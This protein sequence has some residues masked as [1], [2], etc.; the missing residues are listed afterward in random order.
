MRLAYHAGNV[1][2]GGRRGGTALDMGTGTGIIALHLQSRGWRCIAADNNKRA[3]QCAT[4][5]AEANK[6]TL[7]VRHSDL[8][9]HVNETFDLIVSSPPC[10]HMSRFPTQFEFLKSLIPKSSTM[11][12][13]MLDLFV[14]RARRRWIHRFLNEA[15]QHLRENGSVMV[16]LYPSELDL[17]QSWEARVLEDIRHIRIVLL[18]SRHG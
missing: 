9:S 5:H 13:A 14:K 15:R 8:F 17:M 4:K 16:V 10:G 7:E 3:L 1:P 18:K 6:M 12:N 11:L 2:G